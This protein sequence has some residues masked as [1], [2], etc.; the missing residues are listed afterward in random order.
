MTRSA[1]RQERRLAERSCA[2]TS[3][4]LNLHNRVGRGLALLRG[5]SLPGLIRSAPLASPRAGLGIVLLGF[6]PRRVAPPGYPA[7]RLQTADHVLLVPPAPAAVQA[8]QRRGRVAATIGT[9]RQVEGPW[10]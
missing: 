4:T 6:A 10:L 8:R 2:G 5:T 7:D 3:A 9:S 1:H